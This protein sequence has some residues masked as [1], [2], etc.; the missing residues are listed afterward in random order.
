MH[1]HRLGLK[2]RCESLQEQI[3]VFGMSKQLKAKILRFAPLSLLLSGAGLGVLQLVAQAPSAP[4]ADPSSALSGA[5]KPFIE[6]NCQTCHNTRLPSG[7]VDMQMLLATPGSL[8]QDHDT[9]DN[10]AYQ[11]RSGAMPPAGSP[12][13]PR[14]E[15]DAALELIS[16]AVAAN[17]AGAPP[18]LTRKM[19]PAT[20]DWLTF[21]YDAERT[22]WARGEKKISKETV[23][24]LQLKWR[25][26][27]DTVPNP[28]NRYSTLTDPIVVNNVPTHDGPKKLVF[29]GSLDNT[30]YAID[31]DKGT[32]VWQRAYPNKDKPPV[33]ATGN[34]PNNMNATPVV[35]RQ[36]GIIYFLPNDGKL[37]GLSILDGEDRFPATGIVPPYSR[38]FSLNILDGRIFSSTTRGCANAISE[39]VGI[40]VTNPDHPISQFYTSTGKA[41]G[42]WGRGG[43]VVTPFGVVAQTADGAYDPPAA[44]GA[45]R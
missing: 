34:C 39:I 22:G 2:I 14:E 6:K 41:S 12:K 17:P 42:V 28:V 19:A 29:V 7:S 10:M 13:P 9:W 11:I 8:S 1:K 27:T 45:A 43:I 5:V 44:D 4:A 23:S 30:L 20:N 31:A 25:L 36:S 38:N 26:Q 16:R 15:M 21:S 18:D 3:Q 24:R 32:I 35:D 40:D 37:R 33:A